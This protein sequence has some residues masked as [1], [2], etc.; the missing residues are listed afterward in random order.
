MSAYENIM[1]LD[2]AIKEARIKLEKA[3]TKKANRNNNESI[4]VT[5]IEQYIDDLIAEREDELFTEASSIAN[6]T[7]PTW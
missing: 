4:D 3:R 5:A 2:M 7:T 6:K 1:I